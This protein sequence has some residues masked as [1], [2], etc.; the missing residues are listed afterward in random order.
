MKTDKI[1]KKDVLDELMWEPSI[2][3]TKLGVAVNN[4]IVTLS[5]HVSA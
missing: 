2:D 1:L 4:G 5:G 3:A